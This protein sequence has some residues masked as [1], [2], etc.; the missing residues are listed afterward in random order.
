MGIQGDTIL[1]DRGL[2]ARA[3]PGP[4]GR[5]IFRHHCAGFFTALS[6]IE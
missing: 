6:S 1:N 3:H 4:T 2:W 5:V